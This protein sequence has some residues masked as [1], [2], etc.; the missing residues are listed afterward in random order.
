MSVCSPASW[1]SPTRSTCL[2]GKTVGVDSTTL[3]ANAAMRA[4][5]RKD[6]GEDYKAYLRR[7]AK[8]AGMENPTDEELIRFDRKRKDKTTSNTDW[9]S[10]TDGSSRIAKMK[11]GRTHLAYKAE[12]AVDLDTGLVLAA[13]IHSADTGDTATLVDSVLRTQVNLERADVGIEVEE[14]VADKGYHKAEVLAECAELGWR[15][16]IPEPERKTRKW[17]DKP[18][19][20]RVATAANRRRVKGE[21]SKRLQT[22]RSE[23]VERSFAHVCETGGGRRTWLRGRENVSKRYLIVVA[24]HN[25]GVVLRSLF[26]VGKP[27]VLQGAGGGVFPPG[28]WLWIVRG[29]WL[30]RW[31]VRGPSDA[32]ADAIGATDPNS[33]GKSAF[34]TGCQAHWPRSRSRSRRGN[35][36]RNPAGNTATTDTPAA[37]PSGS[38]GASSTNCPNVPTAAAGSIGPTGPARESSKTS[39]PIGTPKSPN[40][41]H[42]DWCPG[43]RKPVEPVVPDAMPACTVGNQA[44]TLSAVLHYGVW[45]TTSQVVVV[46]TPTCDGRSAR[47]G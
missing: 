38:I 11:D 41:I 31:C 40:M 10:A 20:W 32:V 16:Y 9:E 37:S 26:G 15:T 24:A 46:P 22:K 34:S 19:A 35:G 14:V 5:V 13:G 3:E 45:T 18:D 39:R 17:T 44:V 12:H 43:C 2:K 28:V 21:R 8:D 27:R 25:L 1:P 42:P 36:G 29:R 7:L 23:V 4:I 47:A 6:T 30:G 33:R